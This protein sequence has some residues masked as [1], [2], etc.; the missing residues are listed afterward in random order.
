MLRWS[1]AALWVGLL[2]LTLR[3]VIAPPPPPPPLDGL[4]RWSLHFESGDSL[5]MQ[6]ISGIRGVSLWVWLDTRSE[7]NYVVYFLDARSGDPT[8]Q[9]S[10]T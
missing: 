10:S 1:F 3:L 9:F 6:T 5:L 8:G 2:S 7:A 4:R